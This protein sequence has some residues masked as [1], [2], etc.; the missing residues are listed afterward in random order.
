MTL[1]EAIFSFSLGIG[2]S[3]SLVTHTAT[4]TVPSRNSCILCNYSLYLKGVFYNFPPPKRKY[5]KVLRFGERGN[6]GIGP[7]RP[8]HPVGKF[9]SRQAE[10]RQEKRDVAPANCSCRNVFSFIAG[11]FLSVIVG[12]SKKKGSIML[13]FITAHHTLTFGIRGSYS[14]AC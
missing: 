4:L 3:I 1:F 13:F 11:K 2:E 9:L 10:A 12:F 5:V 14:I 8:I 6:E 7:A